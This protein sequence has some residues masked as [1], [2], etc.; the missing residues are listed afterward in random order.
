MRDKKYGIRNEKV[1]KARSVPMLQY[2]RDWA[3]NFLILPKLL[4]RSATPYSLFKIYYSLFYLLP[5]F[6]GIPLHYFTQ[7]NQ[8]DSIRWCRFGN[9]Q[10]I[11]L[12]QG[13]VI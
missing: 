10:G 4:K 2:G 13:L 1:K 11:V 9:R 7:P 6:Y 8:H 5:G 12:L 3:V